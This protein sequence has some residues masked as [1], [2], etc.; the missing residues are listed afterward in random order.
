MNYIRSHVD[1]RFASCSEVIWSSGRAI[2][3]DPSLWDAYLIRGRAY[4]KSNRLAE[5]V[6]DLNTYINMAGQ[7]IDPQELAQIVLERDRL[8]ELQ[9]PRPYG[10]PAT[11]P[12]NGRTFYQVLEISASADRNAVDKAHRR[13]Q[14]KHHPG[15]WALPYL[16]SNRVL[17]GPFICMDYFRAS[18]LWI[19]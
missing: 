4:A 3:L 11:R 9:H 5:A 6:S 8:Q 13:Q 15:K 7:H 1:E 12:A 16:S 19:D 18:H 17:I 14:F 2:Q 10:M